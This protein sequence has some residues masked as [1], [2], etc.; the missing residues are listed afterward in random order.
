LIDKGSLRG[1]DSV[2]KNWELKSNKSF[3]LKTGS[4][5]GADS[6]IENGELKSN[7]SFYLK[8][9]SLRGASPLFRNLFSPFPFIKGKGD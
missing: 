6:V 8:T 4:L 3:Y 2:I 1:A 5:R 7:K 9:G